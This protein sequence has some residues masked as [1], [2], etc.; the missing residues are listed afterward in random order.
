MLKKNHPHKDQVQRL[1][2]ITGLLGDDLGC[3]EEIFYL[4][5]ELLTKSSTLAMLCQFNGCLFC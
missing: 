1:I 3:D 5:A 4:F 2:P